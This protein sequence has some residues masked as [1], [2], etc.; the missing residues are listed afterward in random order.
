V[1]GVLRLAYQDRLGLAVWF[2]I[3]SMLVIGNQFKNTAQP[4]LIALM[5]STK[6]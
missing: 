1:I 5:N 6:E 3:G 2:R 4:M